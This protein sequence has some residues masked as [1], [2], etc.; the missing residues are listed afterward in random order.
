MQFQ[1]ASDFNT[2]LSEEA[3]FPFFNSG[4]LLEMHLDRWTPETPNGKFPRTLSEDTNNRQVSS[5][6]IKD[7]NY[8]R[9]KNFE[10]GYNFPDETISKLSLSKLRIYVSGLNIFTI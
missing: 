10:V 1:G 3:A 8:L 5:F 9:F 7:A 4:K 2:Y 6:W